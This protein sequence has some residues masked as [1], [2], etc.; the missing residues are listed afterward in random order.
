M[1]RQVVVASIVFF[2][3][4]AIVPSALAAD[5]SVITPG[6]SPLNCS[7]PGIDG[8]HD[9]DSGRC[10]GGRLSGQTV[11]TAGTPAVPHKDNR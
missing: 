6:A 9:A 8:K 2:S 10:V 5:R 4:T 7:Q 1:V 3:W 11:R